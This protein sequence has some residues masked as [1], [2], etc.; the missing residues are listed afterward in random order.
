LEVKTAV[1][2]RERKGE[3]EM[4]YITFLKERSIGSHFCNTVICS[5]N[6]QH[7]WCH[8]ANYLSRLFICIKS[9]EL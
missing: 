4:L 1:R 8:F 5:W 6:R 7:S 2:K 9:V 3:G